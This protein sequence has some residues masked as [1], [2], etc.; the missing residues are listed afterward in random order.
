MLPDAPQIKESDLEKCR[1]TGDFSPVLFEWYKFVAGLCVTFSNLLKESPVVRDDISDRDYAILTGLINRA[2]RLMLANIA[3]SHEGEFG[4]S[5]SILD[6]CI[7]ESSVVLSWLCNTD[8]QDGFDRYIASGLRTELEIAEQINGAI[9]KRGTGEIL[10]IEKRM[11]ESVS[12]CL[13]EA[14]FDEK[15]IRDTKGLPDLA[16]M[17]SILGY[18]RFSYT[19]GQ[20]VGSHHV[21][22]TWVGLRYHYVEKDENGK[23]R[24]KQKSNTHENQY[25][26]VTF[27]VLAALADFVNFVFQ[28]ADEERQEILGLFENTK[29]EITKVS[30]EA[31]GSDFEVTQSN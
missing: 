28:N 23:Y 24:A 30:K 16:A 29:E 5:T 13:E 7:F 25:V 8:V 14:G 10:Q 31:A 2:Y 11:L 22:G 20:R 3:L 17:L 18:Q 21:H 26:Y 27:I 6:R 4:E 15:K 9:A 19:A 1:E 12:R